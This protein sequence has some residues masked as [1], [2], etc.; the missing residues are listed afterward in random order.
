MITNLKE[1]SQFLEVPQCKR[2]S[3]ED[4]LKLVTECY[5]FVSVELKDAHYSISIHKIFK[6]SIQNYFKL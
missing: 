3:S 6:I 5:Y 2:E 1:F 4:A